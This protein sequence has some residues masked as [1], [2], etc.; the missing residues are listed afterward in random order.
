MS[1]KSSLIYDSDSDTHCYEECFEDGIVY[2]EQGREEIRLPMPTAFAIA[3]KLIERLRSIVTQAERSDDDIRARV[4]RDV[5]E[6]IEA[7]KAAEATGRPSLRAW[8]GSGIYGLPGSP[9]QEQ[10][11]YGI[12]ETTKG[13]DWAREITAATQALIKDDSAALAAHE[14]GASG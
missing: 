6:R 14:E 13:R 11:K 3:L 9:E 4:E 12:T 10:I 8:Y 7:Y 2:I 5:E 1:T